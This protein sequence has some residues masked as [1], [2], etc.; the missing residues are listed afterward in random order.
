MRFAWESFRMRKE[1]KARTRQRIVST[2]AECFRAQGYNATGI[3]ELM[4]KSGLTNGAFYAHFSSKDHLLSEVAVEAARQMLEDWVEGVEGLS[5]YQCVEVLLARYL[6]TQHR[7]HPQFGCTLPTL[8]AEIAR[9]DSEARQAVEHQLQLSRMPLTQ[10]LM[11]LGIKSADS[12][13][14]GLLSMCVGGITLARAV[15]D[16]KLSTQI[17]DDTLSQAMRLVDLQVQGD[18]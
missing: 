8:G 6:G 11:E 10:A 15:E 18:V 12:L 13:A 17:L 16:A 5:P 4:Q 9:Q 2:A 1:Q 7:D 3:S 14:W